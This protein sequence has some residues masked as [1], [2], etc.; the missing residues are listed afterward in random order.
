MRWDFKR[1]KLRI[2]KTAIP[3]YR[4][5]MFPR[6]TWKEKIL[7]RGNFFCLLIILILAGLIYLFFYSP[8]FKITKIEIT[9]LQNIP[10]D[11]L[12]NK[13]IKWQLSQRRFLIFKQ[14]NLFL[15]SKSWLKKNIENKYALDELKVSKKLFHTLKVN[16]KEKLPK[17]IWITGGQYYYVEANG[18]VSAIADKDKLISNL[19]SVSDTENNNVTVGETILSDKIVNFIDKLN[20][21]IKQETKIT[22][23]NYVFP[24]RKSTQVNAIS[25]E[26]WVI[27]FEANHDL[28]SQISNL[29]EALDKKIK[30]TKTLE[31]IDLRVENHVYYKNK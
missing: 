16:V 23:T 14:D 29:K 12:E 24:E 11:V 1:K 25:N 19:P 31:Y 10:Q 15:F 13:L 2:Q 5:P 21:K 17:L 7:K 4:N 8:V 9:G 3:V 26:G 20:D 28:D 27:Y 22:V 30:N 6:Y 18:I